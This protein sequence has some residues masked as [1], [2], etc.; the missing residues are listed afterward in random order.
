MHTHQHMHLLTGITQWVRTLIGDCLQ[1]S[2]K[3]GFVPCCD[4]VSLSMFL[5][6]NTVCCNGIIHGGFD[7]QMFHQLLLLSHCN[8]S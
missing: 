7:A 3:A 2:T 5:I 8:V 6:D 4:K 1:L